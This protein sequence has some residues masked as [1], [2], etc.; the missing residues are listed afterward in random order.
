VRAGVDALERQLITLARR[1]EVG[2]IVDVGLAPPRHAGRDWTI[3]ALAERQYGV[4]ARWQLL[5]AGIGPGAIDTRLAGHR[6]HRLVR[7]VYAV[8]HTALAPFAEEMA[9]VLACWPGALI[10]HA[11]AAMS[12]WRVLEPREGP[13]ELTVAG[14]AQSRRPSLRVHRTRLLAADDVSVVR[15]IPV[16]SVART[17]VDL[18]ESASDRDL[19]RAFDEALTR[20][21]A[22]ATSVAAA[23]QRAT[24]RRGTKRLKALI[25][26]DTDPAFTRSE[27]EERLLALVRASGLAEPEV[28]ARL[29]GHTVDFV[30]RD[31]RLAVETDGYRYH[32]TRAAFERDRLRDAE[33]TARGF[34]VIRV[35]WR[36]LTE[37]PLAVVA[38]IAAALSP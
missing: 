7:G 6:L 28:N 38:R 19:E 33:L 11:S 3:A 18:A 26:R 2:L 24:G 32:S 29:G 8:G 4:V 20:N 1:A 25:E 23:V 37:Q 34:R 16:T 36:Q 35:T 5:A 27:A 10:S 12:I 21:L 9:A 14:G 15:G 31:K 22:T 30:W 17:L 13:M